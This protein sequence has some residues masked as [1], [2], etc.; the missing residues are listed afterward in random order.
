MEH[1]NHEDPVYGKHMQIPLILSSAN[2]PAGYAQDPLGVGKEQTSVKKNLELSSGKQKLH[3]TSL[4]LTRFCLK[5]TCP[6]EV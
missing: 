4:P 6:P 2:L 3:Q 5:K 1:W